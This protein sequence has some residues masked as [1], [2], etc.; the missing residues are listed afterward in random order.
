MIFVLLRKDSEIHMTWKM[1]CS[2]CP[3]DCDSSQASSGSNICSRLTQN[4]GFGHVDLLQHPG[5]SLIVSFENLRVVDLL[6]VPS[7]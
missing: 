3:G 4:D 6:L 5:T 7:I 2:A 1:S